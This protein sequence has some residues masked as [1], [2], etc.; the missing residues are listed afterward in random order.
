MNVQ[1]PAIAATYTPPVVH[2]GLAPELAALALLEAAIE[3]T[4]AALHAAQPELLSVHDRE[5][6]TS[7]VTVASTIV[8]QALA[9]RG[10]INRYRVTLVVDPG[11]D[12]PLP[13]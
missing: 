6:S 13:F 2:L 12:G 1:G 5:P 7:S 4:T 9:L 11:P 8:A 10:H 3:V